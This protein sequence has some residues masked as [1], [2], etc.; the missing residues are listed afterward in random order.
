LDEHSAFVGQAGRI[1]V[2]KE[3]RRGA[4]GYWYACR[5]LHRHTHKRYLGPSSKVTF[6][7]LEEVV[8]A[9][10]STRSDLSPACGNLI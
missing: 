7:R 9:L 10:A 8:K 2:L 5:T 6:E 3:V 4:R 1:S